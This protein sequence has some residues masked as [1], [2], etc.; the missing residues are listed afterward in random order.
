MKVLIFGAGRRGLSI[1]KHLIDEGVSI[2]F[3]DISPE[4]CQSA[5]AKLDCM[6]IC[7]SATNIERLQEAG[8][9]EADIVIAVT[10]SDEVNIVSCG[11]VSANFPNVEKTIAAIRSV[12]YSGPE[13]ITCKIMGIDHIVNPEQEAAM[14]IAAIIRS[15]LYQDTISF[16]GTDFVLFTNTIDHDSPYNGKTLIEIRQNSDFNFVVAGICRK[17][18]TIIPY[19]DTVI[20]NG[21]T[22]AFVTENRETYDVLRHTGKITKYKEPDDIVII[23]ATRITRY[24]LKSFSVKDR[25]KVKLI[26]KDPALA[27]EFATLF[28]EVLVINAAITD[29]LIWED[30]SIDDSDLVI[31]LTENDELNI[32][33]T[34]YAKRAGA[35]KAIALIRTNTNYSQFALSLDV[36]VALSI[37]DVTADSLM[38]YIRGGGVSAMH[39]MFNGELEAYEYVIQEN[40]KYLGKALKDVNLRNKIIIAGVT[41]ADGS[42]IVPTGNYTFSLNDSLILA[43][44]HQNSN[45]IQ[46]FFS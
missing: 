43:V 15:G 28:P 8:A 23:G 45:Y 2:T 14:R 3:L 27:T 37:T 36:D 17:G 18:Q 11:V 25:R 41:L 38:K 12:S 16:P 20:K 46:E 42:S 30:E 13:G 7:G 4:R 10:N 31:S 35:K 6:A 29:E 33:T 21:D 40:F 44:T 19:G 34:S 1:A 39:T 5:Q 22:L 32:I 24:L 9:D 26:E